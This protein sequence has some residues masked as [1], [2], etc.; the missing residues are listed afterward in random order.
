MNQDNFGS[1]VIPAMAGFLF[2]KR[3]KVQ[4][5]QQ[6][7]APQL[8]AVIKAETSGQT[9]VAKYLLASPLVTSVAKYIKKKEKQPVTG[10]AKYVLRQT[11]ADRNAPPPTGVAKYIAKAA[12]EVPTR[13]KSSIDKYLL[14]QELAEKKVSTLTGVARYNAEQDLQ[15]RKK[16]A[17]T[18]IERYREQEEATAKAAR[19]EAEVAYELS[20]RSEQVEHEVEAPA[21]TRVGR[22]LQEQAQLL[23][24]QPKATS[25]SKYIA[26]KIAA[27]SLKPE[28]S[29]SKV[30]KYLRDQ[31]LAQNKKP[32]LTG[33]AKYISKQPPAAVKTTKPKENLAESG[34]ARYMAAQ[35]AADSNKPVLSGVA[36]YLEKQTQLAR[37]AMLRLPD[38]TG[39]HISALEGEFIPANNFVP[40]GVSRY[41]EKQSADVAVAAETSG[42]S[43]GV[44]RYINSQSSS[45][46]T[47][48]L[49]SAPTKVDKY[50]LNRAA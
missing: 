5:I 41:L 10:V 33:V 32:K 44:S 40:T 36:K 23:K 20:S 4:E 1:A 26:K 38:H 22:Y 21:G 18:M 25:V 19:E 35:T 24:K 30:S 47:R 31:A 37:E 2:W 16:A 27:D 15:D 29:M 46:A 9:G 17:T 13:K 48:T 7:K 3:A 49:T 50:L 34:V 12:K 43:T 45:S 11:I 14:K 39:S 8:P 42:R 28:L 6:V